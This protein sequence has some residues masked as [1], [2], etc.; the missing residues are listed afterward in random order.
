MKDEQTMPTV[1]RSIGLSYSGNLVVFTTQKQMTVKAGVYVQ[2]L[3]EPLNS[4][5]KRP[6]ILHAQPEQQSNACLFSHLDDTVIF[7]N[8]GTLFLNRKKA[9]IQVHKMGNLKCMI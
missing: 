6:L 8:G 2:D 1:L 4:E 3:R 7:G 5:G 9:K